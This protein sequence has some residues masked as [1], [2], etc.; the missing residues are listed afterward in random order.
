[1]HLVFGCRSAMKMPETGSGQTE[2]MKKAQR[3]SKTVG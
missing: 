3:L 1:V 2:L